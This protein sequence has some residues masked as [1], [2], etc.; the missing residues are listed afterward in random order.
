MNHAKK[1]NMGYKKIL[2]IVLVAGG[3]ALLAFSY[4]IKNQVEGGKGRIS[5]AQEQVDTGNR[6]FAVDPTSKQVGKVV[7]APAQS[8]INQGNRDVAHY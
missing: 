1:W 3:L 8:R 5:S 7:M 2:G 6:L 4:Y